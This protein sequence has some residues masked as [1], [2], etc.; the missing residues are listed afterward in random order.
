MPSFKN[1]KFTRMRTLMT[2][3]TLEPSEYVELKEC[4]A[5]GF[6]HANAHRVQKLCTKVGSFDFTSS[7]PSVMVAEKFP[8]TRGKYLGSVELKYILENIEKKCFMFRLEL[9][10][11]EPLIDCDHPI[12]YYKCSADD[13]VIEAG[14]RVKDCV[15]DNGRIVY[16][17][18]LIT[19]CTEQDLLTYLEFYKWDMDRMRIFDCYEY[20]KQYLPYPFVASILKLYE[21]KT[22]LKDVDGEEVNY[23]IAKGMLNS[24]Y[25]MTVTDIVR[26]ELY[27]DNSH[28]NNKGEWQP[29][30]SN[31]DLMKEKGR[32][33]EERL[34]NEFLI[35][36]I[37]RY[38]ANPYR[39]LFYVWGVWVTAY[40]RRNLF[41]GIRECAKD[42]IYADTDSIKI[43]NPMKHMDYIEK[44][45]AE[46]TA[47]LEKA[48]IFHELDFSL[49][50]PKNKYGEEKPLGIW[51]FEGVYD[52]FMTLG[53]K[54]YMWRKDDKWTLTVA[55]VNKTSGMQYLLKLAEEKSN[56]KK[57][58]TPFD[59]F[60]LDLTFPTSYSGRNVL[61]Y[62]DQEMSGEI[63]DYLGNVNTFDELSSIHM[64]A[65]EYSMNPMQNFLNYLFSIKEDSW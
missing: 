63:E 58:Y 45:N 12:S 15:L 48:C 56:S 31:Y 39:F 52:E 47:K 20:T 3:M 35:E 55:G 49:T 51:E 16:A 38:N 25:G 53:A 40:A 24:L 6:T 23:Q 8:I 32:D 4:F 21:D 60:N 17:Q 2:R 5:G 62:I 10:D 43:L 18:H 28:V 7:Y 36:Q 29:F 11:V 41:C 64:E 57:K 19:T 33:E 9:F 59:F 30:F 27:Y 26:E 37:D 65:T 61:T 22:K 44:Y 13:T 54:R 14:K 50:K 46:I 42:Y 1:W 34:Y